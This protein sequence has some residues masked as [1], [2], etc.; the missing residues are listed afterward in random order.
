MGAEGRNGAH[1]LIAIPSEGS[2]GTEIR[3][4]L[5]EDLLVP[6]RGFRAV[7]HTSKGYARPAIR[8]RVPSAGNIWLIGGVH[9]PTLCLL[10]QL[11]RRS[12]G[13]RRRKE[14]GLDMLR[15]YLVRKSTFRR[16]HVRAVVLMQEEI[17]SGAKLFFLFV[18]PNDPN[19]LQQMDADGDFERGQRAKQT[20]VPPTNRQRDHSSSRLGWSKIQSR[21]R[22]MQEYKLLH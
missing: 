19:N 3:A 16:L 6:D 8:V 10:V 20:G 9:T 11:C 1:H 18:D 14:K 15:E 7:P 21:H 4:R 2:I 13:S 12:R 22:N 5:P 17:W